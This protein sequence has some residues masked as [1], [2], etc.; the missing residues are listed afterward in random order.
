MDF[1]KNLNIKSVLKIIGIALLAILALSFAY[2]LLGSPLSNLQSSKTSSYSM[3]GTPAIDSF[4]VDY[5]YEEAAFGEGVIQELSIRNT[6]P[7]VDGGNTTGGDA[8]DFEVTDYY[9]QIETS[10]LDETCRVFQELKARDYVIFENAQEYEHGCTYNFKVER[11]RTEEV[12]AIIEGLDPKN[13]TANTRTIKNRIEDFTSEQEVLERKRD[14]IEQTLED[15]IQSYDEIAAVATQ[16][17]DAE[18]LAKIIDSKIRI[19]ERL[20]QQRIAV[21]EQLDRLA[22]SKAIQLDRLDYTNFTITISE[23][24]FV[25]GD[26][27]KDSWRQAVRSFVRD[28]NETLQDISINLFAVLFRGAL[29]VVYLVIILYVAKYGWRY[30]QRVWK[31]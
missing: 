22:R 28:I 30:A 18:S 3:R 12:L 8:E 23:N 31:K 5:G 11:D 4:G 17:R 26:Q 24:K 19:I 10:D 13:L 14:S 2:R 7:P 9:G 15:A 1:L 27:I 29:I 6:I 21:N 25:D 16:A 20:S